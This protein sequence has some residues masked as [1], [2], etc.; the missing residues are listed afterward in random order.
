MTQT[1]DVS[2][3][4]DLLKAALEKQPDLSLHALREQLEDD[5]SAF[6][7]ELDCTPAEAVAQ[8][9]EKAHAV[10]REI[11][12][13]TD[14]PWS[15]NEPMREALEAAGWR[16]AAL[17]GIVDSDAGADVLAS[18]RAKYPQFIKATADGTPIWDQTDAVQFVRELTGQPD[19]VCKRWLAYDWPC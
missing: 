15:G 5:A 13:G 2:L 18:D 19:D 3:D 16:Y 6:I 17:I 1:V 12:Y 10:L 7:R 9:R 14:A 11:V 4:S 8:A